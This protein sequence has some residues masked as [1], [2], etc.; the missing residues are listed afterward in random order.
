[1]SKLWNTKILKNAEKEREITN[2]LTS[3]FSYLYDLRNTIDEDVKEEIDIYNNI[4]K[5]NDARLAHQKKYKIN[6]L[7]AVVQTM[8]AR[9]IQSLF[10]RENYIK[11]YIENET[12]LKYEKPLTAF[13][14]D[15]LDNMRLK[16]RSRD[17]LEEALVQRGTFLQ[18]RPVKDPDKKSFDID[19][20]SLNFFDVWYDLMS[21]K[22]EDTDFFIRKIVFLNDIKFN[23]KVYF[24]TDKIDQTQPPDPLREKQ[25]Y[26]AKTGKTYY[27]PEKNNVTDKV[28][29]LEWYGRYDM[30]DNKDEPD[31]KEMI[32]T[33]ANRQLLVR[34]DEVTLE[35]KRKRLFFPI[36]P[37]RMANS[38]MSKG[39]GQL[40]KDPQYQLNETAS[41]MMDNIATLCGLLFKYKRDGSIDVKELF[42][43]AGNGIGWE[44]APTDIDI[45]QIPNLVQVLVGVQREIIQ[46]MQQISGSVDYVM[47]TS[48][49]RGITETATGISKITEQALFKFAMMTENIVQD[50][51][52]M[53]N[54]AV[55]LK[56]KY[57]KETILLEYPE[58]EGFF[59]T[60]ETMIEETKYFDIAIYDLAMRREVERT[61]FINLLNIIAPLVGQN[62]GNMRELLRTIMERLQMDN[63]DAILGSDAQFA[64]QQ[65]QQAQMQQMMA[66]AGMQQQAASQQQ[67]A[68]QQAPTEQSPE[69]AASQLNTERA[70]SRAL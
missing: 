64:Q 16:Y 17:F 68:Q 60:S 26:Q 25:V 34:A 29:L 65:A 24:N 57:D 10:G 41:R 31:F 52:D 51:M 43:G 27:D 8:V 54:Y 37:L 48:A 6:Y 58:L 33:L 53:V 67:K 19:F 59:A 62:G 12:M 45:F 47:G 49:G 56:F 9:I 22:V 28:E 40:L 21:S 42:A 32:F 61:Q 50:I 30:S 35:T 4:D 20:M 70:Q 23:D 15:M 69:E 11:I 44:G 13:V 46:N 3:R 66:M 38:L 14:Q 36:R 1:M 18:L 63:V 5:Y 7:Y 55:V 2:F 39:I